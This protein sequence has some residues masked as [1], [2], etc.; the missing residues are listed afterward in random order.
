MTT[1]ADPWRSIAYSVRN[2]PAS[3]GLRQYSVSV[4]IGTWSGDHVGDGDLN[5]QITPIL[6]SGGT[7]PKVRFMNEEQR[8]LSGMEIGSCEVGPITP[9]FGSNGTPLSYLLPTVE[10]GET[11]HALITGPQFPNGAKFSIKKV[12]TDHALHWKM[13]CEPVSLSV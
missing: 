3:F 11:V 6:E 4:V 1:L 10:S 5:E 7:N 2:I 13:L 12:E 8:T 9:D